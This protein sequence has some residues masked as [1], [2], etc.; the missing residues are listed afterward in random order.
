MPLGMTHLDDG[1]YYVPGLI[2]LLSSPF[3]DKNAWKN[4]GPSRSVDHRF[5]GKSSLFTVAWHWSTTAVS[6]QACILQTF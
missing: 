4:F 2:L 1:R 6:Q 5:L 3:Q